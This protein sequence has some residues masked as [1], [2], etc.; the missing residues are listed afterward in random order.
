MNRKATVSEINSYLK[1][2]LDNDIILRDIWI[3]GEISN[4][5]H[6]YSGHMY[7][8][9][10]D[11][12]SSIKAVMFKG[13]NMSLSFMPEDGMSVIARG[14]ISV[15]PAGGQYQLY[16]EEMVLNGEGDL[17]VAFE[18]LKEKLQNEGLFD[19]KYKKPIP[20]FPETVGVVTSATGAAVR[21][22]INVLTRRFKSVNI[23]LYPVLVQGDGAA[24]EIAKAIKSFNAQKSA[25][26]IIVGRGGGSIEDLWAFN[27]EVVARAV[28]ESEIPVISAV[29]H[30]T[31]FTICDFVSDLRAPTP[32]AA[33]ELAVPDSFEILSY[34]NSL[35]AVFSKDITSKIKSYGDKISYFEKIISPSNTLLKIDSNLQK[36]DNIFSSLE[37]NIISKLEKYEAKLAVNIAKIDAL[38]PLK[39]LSRGYSVVYDNDNNLVSDADKLSVGDNIN[40]KL[41][42]G[43]A[44]CL[45]EEVIYE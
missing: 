41:C 2:L 26:V 39:I 31:D 29:G 28:F 8:S 22:I 1:T 27:E 25:D 19:E 6:H 32:S 42:K 12:T 4:F 18:K 45:V 23:L 36:L 33:A 11:E 9:L 20:K 15:F 7:M 10:K 43:K 40:I 17:H 24:E 14:R 37:S 3:V 34:L 38:S 35:S 30:E 21:D 16:I 5:K 44:K 13:A